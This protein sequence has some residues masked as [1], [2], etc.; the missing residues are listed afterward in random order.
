MTDSAVTPKLPTLD[1]LRRIF[2]EGVEQVLISG[3]KVQMRPVRPDQLIAS[4][5]Q[6]PDPLMP[7]MLKGI[8]QDI[9][10]DLDD[11][12]SPDKEKENIVEWLRSIDVVCQASLV[13]PS[14]VPYLSLTDKLWI[15]RLAFLPAEA[16]ATFRWQPPR[17]VDAASDE[18]GDGDT[19]EPT[20]VSVA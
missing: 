10:Q 4:G 14:L 2:D 3:S 9:R 12:I 15:F 20:A 16:L 19:P 11:Y 8:F 13:D 17:D 6:I 7:I 5:I 18:Q 1:E